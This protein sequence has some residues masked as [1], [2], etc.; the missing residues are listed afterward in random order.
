M[1]SSPAELNASDAEQTPAIHKMDNSCQ[2]HDLLVAIHS[3]FCISYQISKDGYI[4]HLFTVCSFSPQ[5]PPASSCSF[6]CCSLAS[7]WSACCTLSG[8]S[9]TMTLP[10]V[11]DAGCP[12]C[13]A[14]NFGTTCAITSPSRWE[15]AY[16]QLLCMAISLH[17]TVYTVYAHHITV[18]KQP[19]SPCKVGWDLPAQV[20]K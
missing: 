1:M 5:H 10:H 19:R 17:F 12:S 4:M 7:G 13:V 2:T 14:S 11:E 3:V 9:L 8:G 15:T 16:R 20:R 6:T 18:I